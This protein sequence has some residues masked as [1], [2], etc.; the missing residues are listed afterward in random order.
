[1]MGTGNSHARTP[2]THK[3]SSSSASRLETL[4]GSPYWP[5][6]SSFLKLLN[7]TPAFCNNF[8]LGAPST[9][10]QPSK[11]DHPAAPPKN[12]QD[13]PEQ[14][15]LDLDGS[16][17]VS[18]AD[19]EPNGDQHEEEEEEEEDDDLALVEELLV[20]PHSAENRNSVRKRPSLSDRLTEP[21]SWTQRAYADRPI[22][23]NDYHDH[24][25]PARLPFS[26][27]PR[28][29][30]FHI[31]GLA[32]LKRSTHPSPPFRTSSNLIECN[33]KLHPWGNKRPNPVPTSPQ[34]SHSYNKRARLSGS[35][36][37]PTESKKWVRDRYQ[38]SDDEYEDRRSYKK[39]YYQRDYSSNSQQKV[40]HPKQKSADA[41][42]LRTCEPEGRASSAT[43]WKKLG[44][45]I[46]STKLKRDQT[47]QDLNDEVAD[48]ERRWMQEFKQ[49]DVAQ[50]AR[51]RSI[52]PL[53]SSHRRSPSS[54]CPQSEAAGYYTLT[55]LA[56]NVQ[57]AIH[58]AVF[59]WVNRPI[60]EALFRLGLWLEEK[61]IWAPNEWGSIRVDQLERVV[62]LTYERGLSFLLWKCNSTKF[63]ELLQKPIQ[64]GIFFMHKDP[65][66][67][68][69][70]IRFCRDYTPI[71]LL[72]RAL[73]KGC[74]KHLSDSKTQ[75]PIQTGKFVRQY[76]MCYPNEDDLLYLFQDDK[77]PMGCLERAEKDGIIE[78]LDQPSTSQVSFGNRRVATHGNKK[79]HSNSVENLYIRLKAFWL[80][81]KENVDYALLS[82]PTTTAQTINTTLHDED[83]LVSNTT[84]KT[85]N[86][87]KSSNRAEQKNRE[88]LVPA[89]DRRNSDNTS[90]S[91]NTASTS[92]D[93]GKKQPGH[94]ALSDHPEEA[95]EE[96]DDARSHSSDAIEMIKPTRLPRS[97]STAD[98]MVQTLI[99]HLRRDTSRRYKY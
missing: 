18:D 33:T 50:S 94:P 60:A 46:G 12:Q 85:T 36:Q 65:Q 39:N 67:N 80:T 81:N 41:S 38:E 5:L 47:A 52:S 58:R 75:Q 25:A 28:N 40:E 37:N 77:D 10:P 3:P 14:M 49:L 61:K 34:S 84:S 53:P 79:S 56:P 22:R 78:L 96:D 92:T 27:I 95:E 45:Q 48:R 35:S 83:D 97:C 26:S 76:I 82:S 68:A 57:E 90:V 43:A 70:Y 54:H 9:E 89:I 19:Q 69:T 74:R 32:N 24:R 21:S 86:K 64:S 1:M 72:Y 31:K 2:I 87:L 91:I 7:L 23:E 44:I 63:L 93:A 98:D 51:T 13:E 11:N 88:T 66:N 59:S 55:P 15:E 6:G 62:D 30:N 99:E 71:G 29:T 4:L 42:S 17:I 20:Q 8:R 73:I 16:P